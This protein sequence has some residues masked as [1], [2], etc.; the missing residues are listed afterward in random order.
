M[1]FIE[2]Y[3]PEEIHET[4]VYLSETAL[5]TG[6][7]DL[8]AFARSYLA[9]PDLSTAYTPGAKGYTDYPTLTGA[10]EYALLEG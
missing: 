1:S 3:D 7:A 4:Y 6:F 8:V 5:D 2:P 9:N 10:V